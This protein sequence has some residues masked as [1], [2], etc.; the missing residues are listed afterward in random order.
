MST[1][2]QISE[3]ANVALLDNGGTRGLTQSSEDQ[4][5]DTCRELEPGVTPGE[6][7]AEFDDLNK[8]IT[9]KLDIYVASAR[10]AK[11]DFDALLPELD[12]MQAMLSQRGRLRPLMDTIGMPTWT[13]WF[14]QFRKRL[15]EDFTIRA[16]QRKLRQYRGLPDSTVAESPNSDG[17]TAETV[18][19][20]SRE[21]ETR[22]I[23]RDQ[24]IKVS[25]NAQHRRMEAQ[26]EY[27]ERQKEEGSV[28]DHCK[29]RILRRVTV[30]Q[31][32]YAEPT[33]K[34]DTAAL[35]KAVLERVIASATD[36]DFFDSSVLKKRAGELSRKMKA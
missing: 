21:D 1:G 29:D 9:T 10:K 18:Q 30:W 27:V 26:A 23:W 13:E 34:V 6:L 2:T 7:R 20:G 14:K 31:A 8:Q 25:Y 36:T 33:G 19:P 11:I 15:G 4:T 12:Q 32:V 35:T 5:R 17:T 3:V 28:G 22:P 24:H 16:I